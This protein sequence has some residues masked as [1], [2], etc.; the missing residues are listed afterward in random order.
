MKIFK[1]ILTTVAVFA[2][3]GAALSDTVPVL[4][5]YGKF[6]EGDGV[7]IEMAQFVAKNKDGLNDVLIKMIGANA[8]SAG[9][10][11]KVLKYQ[12]VP[13]STGVDY[14]YEGS[15][16]MAVRQPYSDSSSVMQVFL[17]GK[18]I[19]LNEDKDRSKKVRPLHLLTESQSTDK[20]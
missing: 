7:E 11:G 9:I 6:L 13:G 14:R 3:Q 17:D 2:L 19:K 4:N 5:P 1:I 18:T 16:R 12:A 15:T 20:K 10:D 8:F